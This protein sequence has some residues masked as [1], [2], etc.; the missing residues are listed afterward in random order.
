MAAELYVIGEISGAHSFSGDSF[1]CTFEIITGTQWTHVEGA[2]KGST[3]VMQNSHDGVAWS[4]P[5]DAHF[6]MQA[7]QGWPRIALQVWSVDRYGRKDLAG[8]GTCFVPMPSHEETTV[9]VATWKP[10]YWHSNG[11]MR[12][13]QQVRQMV[14]GGNPV[15]KDDNLIHSNESR[16]KLHTAS[17]G[18]VVLKL[19]VLARN[20]ASLGL[21][22]S[23]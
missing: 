17:G 21:K 11:F 2:N 3:H 5:I 4:Y 8:Y 6:G 13:M 16:C 23:A 7:V 10:T 9:E 15:L 1:F 12:V 14:M 18:T 20:T 22:F 19:S